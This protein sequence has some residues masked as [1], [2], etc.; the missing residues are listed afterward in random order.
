MT[1][2]GTSSFGHDDAGRLTSIQHKNG[3][4]VNLAYYV[5]GYDN[6]NRLTSESLNGTATGTYTYDRTNQVIGDGSNTLGYDLSGN[7]TVVNGQ[8]YV[9]GNDNRLTSDGTWTYSYDLEGNVIKKTK[10]ANAETW[11]YQYD[12]ANH[13]TNARGEATDT[14]P[15]EA[16]TTLATYVYDVFENR[17]EQIVTQN[18]TTTDT[19]FAYDGST[20]WADLNSTNQIVPE[21]HSTPPLRGRH[22]RGTCRC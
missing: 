3:S 14:G 19:R 2:V 20:I 21:W 13:L 15:T 12:N 8:G 10:G 1:M 18:G 6:A 9:T 7:R 16:F 4:G 22:R 17:I 5:D 11:Y